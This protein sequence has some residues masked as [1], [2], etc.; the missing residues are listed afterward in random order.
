MSLRFE[1]TLERYSLLSLKAYHSVQDLRSCYQLYKTRNYQE[2]R[3]TRYL[4]HGVH[5]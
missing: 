5:I 1:G 2:G 3:G 4:L